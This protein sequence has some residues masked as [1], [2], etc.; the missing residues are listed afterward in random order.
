MMDMGNNFLGISSNR[1]K[2][3]FYPTPKE[4]TY[5]FINTV[6]WPKNLRIWEPACGQNHMVN[7]LST[8]FDS[9]IG[10]DIQTGNDFLASLA[11]DVDACVT[12]PPFSLS[13]SLIHI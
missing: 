11:L 4:V 5:A 12:N 3:D 1:N 6:C 10:T 8:Y 7:V 9:V 2:N 13:L